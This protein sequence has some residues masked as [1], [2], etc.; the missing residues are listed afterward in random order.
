MVKT[1]RHPA[2]GTLVG[3]GRNACS[4][5]SARRGASG[6][7][8][9]V[10]R[11]SRCRREATSADPLEAA[12]S[13][14]ESWSGSAVTSMD[15][16]LVPPGAHLR[17]H[18]GSHGCYVSCPRPLRHLVCHTEPARGGR[19]RMVEA[20][21]RL[22][23]SGH[24]AKDA[25]SLD[26]HRTD[27]RMGNTCAVRSPRVALACSGGRP[28]PGPQQPVGPSARVTALAGL[29]T[30]GSPAR[31][32]V[33]QLTSVLDPPDVSLLVPVS[34]WLADRR[35]ASRRSYRIPTER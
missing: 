31:L 19:D 26:D 4:L 25:E 6:R 14:S 10:G 27:V 2:H 17:Q 22:T 30:R 32:V 24:Q 21:G 20:Q 28:S 3:P 18:R 13:D 35:P 33:P 5:I 7:R 34:F 12:G 8:W 15:A 16:S 23:S 1:P 9:G 11:C 29:L